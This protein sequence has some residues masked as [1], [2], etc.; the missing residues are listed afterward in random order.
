[1]IP[2][3]PPTPGVIVVG[4]PGSRR[5]ALFGDALAARGI[6]PARVVSYADLLLG[7]VTL[8]AVVS[9]RSILRIESPERDFEVERGLIAAGA[10]EDDTETTASR[11]GRAQ[12]LSLEFDHGR[13]LYPRQWYL[14]FRKLLRQLERQ[15]LSCPP[16]LVMNRPEDIEVMFDK[17]SCHALF[18]A[19]D[20]PC[21]RGL[22]T[23]GSYDDLRQRMA[24]SGISRVFVKLA[25]GSSASGIV[26]LETHG[27]R[28]QAST[29]VEAVEGHG[30][31]KL[32]NTRAIRRMTDEGQIAA[33]VDAL[34]RE[35]AHAEQWV[36]KASLAGGVFDLR[37]VVIG[38]RA[39]H[40]VARVS[41]SPMTNL[42]LLNRRCEASLVRSRMTPDAWDAVGHSCERAAGVVPESLYAGV[43]VVIAPGFRRHAVLE[44]NAFGDLL[45]GLSLEGMDTYT[46]ELAAL[47]AAD[48]RAT[49]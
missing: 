45:P 19:Q 43:D 12:A 33:V 2:D 23:P 42:H 32:Y 22:G 4:N 9:E 7:R 6:G 34:C 18:H 8:E 44:I 31:L 27:Q 36:P 30:E 37:V 20:V 1:M 48:R 11:V 25:H 10:D 15:R 3:G 26:A 13:I 40:T 46:A 29:T 47:D 38:G 14:G 16:H 5:V 21:P 28:V 17:P 24:Q 39:M 35:R 49:S 41:Q